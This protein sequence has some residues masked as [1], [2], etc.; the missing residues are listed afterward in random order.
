MII[1]FVNVLRVPT[2]VHTRTGIEKAFLVQVTFGTTQQVVPRF[3]DKFDQSLVVAIFAN[4]FGNDGH[5]DLS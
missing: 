3:I 4:F 2:I 5:P 1:T